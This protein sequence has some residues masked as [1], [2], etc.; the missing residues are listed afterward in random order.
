MVSDSPKRIGLAR[1]LFFS[2]AAQRRAAIVTRA[3]RPPGSCVCTMPPS[4]L[5]HTDAE[6]HV[7]AAK[8][9]KQLIGLAQVSWGG[10]L[11]ALHASPATPPSRVCMD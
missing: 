6:A 7:I 11:D 5:K 2:A 10:W 4:P 3:R 1:G 9:Y 8:R